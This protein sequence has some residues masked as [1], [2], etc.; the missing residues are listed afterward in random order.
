EHDFAEAG[1]RVFDAEVDAREVPAFRF[2]APRAIALARE[3]LDDADAVDGL[4]ERG[5]QRRHA[6][7]LPEEHRQETGPEPG[8][9]AEKERNGQEDE[10]RE[11]P[12]QAEEDGGDG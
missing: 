6:P 10:Q 11:A 4:V 1:E 12:I 5:M 8:A 9:A 2:E 7:A 3:R